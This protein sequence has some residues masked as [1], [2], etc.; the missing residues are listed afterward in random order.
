[1]C[2]FGKDYEYEEWDRQLPRVSSKIKD[3]KATC[4]KKTKKAFQY[5][6]REKAGKNNK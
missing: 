4:V 1:M 3:S 5:P 6:Q 2:I